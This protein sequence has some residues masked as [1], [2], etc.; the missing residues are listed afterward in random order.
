MDGGEQQNIVWSREGWGA[1]KALPKDTPLHMIN[2]IRLREQAAYPA[3]HPKHG[4]GLS[5]WDAYR[6]YGTES[7]PIF[8]RVGGRQ[9]WLGRPDLVLIGP[10]S[11]QWDIAFIAEYPNADAFIEMQRDPA[12]Q[13]AALNRTAAVRDSRLIRSEPLAAGGGFGMPDG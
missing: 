1:F 9:V 7:A 5:G 11:E 6:A 10:A 8:T 12:Y 2:L 3:D 13:Q 4:K